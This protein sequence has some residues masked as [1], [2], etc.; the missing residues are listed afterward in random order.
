MKN[1][2]ASKQP[3]SVYETKAQ[4]TCSVSLPERR[5]QLRLEQDLALL[6]QRLRRRDPMPRLRF[7]LRGRCAGQARLQEWCIRLNRELLQRYQDAFIEDTVPHE[8]AHLVAF[9]M[10]GPGIQ[11]H[12]RQWRDVMALLG[13]QPEVCHRYEVKPA[14][15]IKRFGY[16]CGCR[17]HALSSIRHRR[18][19]QGFSYRCRS[20][21]EILRQDDA[22]RTAC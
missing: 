11:P 20:C 6:N 19:A 3:V 5:A 2:A 13:C 17:A 22:C 18:V 7:D 9:A 4:D 12:G 10:H 21:G 8:L 14:R 1:D 16:R 15:Q